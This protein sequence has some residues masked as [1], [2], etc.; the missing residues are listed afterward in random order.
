MACPWLIR[1][2]INPDARIL[3][4]PADRVLTV[5]EAENGLPFDVPGVELGHHGEHCSFDAFLARYGLFAVT[6]MHQHMIGDEPTL[7]Y[8]HFWRVGTPSEVGTGLKDAL[9][10]VHTAA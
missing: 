4:V 2:F 8:M 10:H 6:A 1:R 9:S 5:A 7:Y 3:F